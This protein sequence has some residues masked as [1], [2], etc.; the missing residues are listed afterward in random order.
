[1]FAD[2]QRWLF[3]C[4]PVSQKK[5]DNGHHKA[6]LLSIPISGPRENCMVPLPVTLLGNS[7]VT[8]MGN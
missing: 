4:I 8:V 3:L 7:Y 5:R 2:M 6:P 1:M